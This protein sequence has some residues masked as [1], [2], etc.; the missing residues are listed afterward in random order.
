MGMETVKQSNKDLRKHLEEQFVFL[1]N[2]SLAYDKGYDAEAKR[3][4]H[5]IRTLLHDTDKSKSLLKQLDLK[6]IK[7]CCTCTGSY[8]AKK[9]NA[10][11]HCLSYVFLGNP[12]ML[13]HLPII[14]SVP[15]GGKWVHFQEWWDKIVIVDSEKNKFKRKRLILTVC[16]KDGGS[17]VDPEIEKNY[18]SLSRENSLGWKY[19][20][21]GKWFDITKPELASIRQMAH[22][23]ILTFINE[24]PELEKVVK[25]EDFSEALNPKRD[26]QGIVVNEMIIIGTPKIEEQNE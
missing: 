16:N 21:D 4:A 23:V 11:F 20:S 2:F 19:G 8:S 14:G 13:K 6:K 15:I 26:L 12:Q 17:H 9:H 18:Y 22:E 7:F 10:G 5:I 25:P 1:I 3:L 24:F